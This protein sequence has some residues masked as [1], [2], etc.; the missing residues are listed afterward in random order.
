[1]LC[2]VT[3]YFLCESVLAC[4]DAAVETMMITPECCGAL[5]IYSLVRHTSWTHAG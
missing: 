4:A 3:G 2:D 1:M 5:T